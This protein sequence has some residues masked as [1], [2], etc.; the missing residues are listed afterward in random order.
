MA[1]GVPETSSARGLDF[2]FE[3]VITTSLEE[4]GERFM[5]L[6][7]KTQDEPSEKLVHDLRVAARR[8]MATL[9][10]VNTVTADAHLDAIWNRLRRWLKASG[11]LRDT[12][13]QVL[14]VRELL[15][16][17]P[18][19]EPFLTILL[20]RE[21]MVIKRIL[22]T[23]KKGTL[24]VVQKDVDAVCGRLRVLCQHPVTR[25]AVEA[26]VSGAAGRAFV[27]ATER[28]LLIDRKR[29]V[30]IHRFRLSFKKLRYTMEALQPFLQGIPGQQ[31]EAMNAYQQKMGDIQDV[32]VLRSMIHAYAVK[33]GMTRNPDLSAVQ[34]ELMSRRVVLVDRFMR[35]AM[36]FYRFW[37]GE[38]TVNS[39]QPSPLKIARASW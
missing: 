13:V 10:I 22:R 17:Y 2:V 38:F 19:L 30:T 26:G 35:A 7:K 9:D 3:A 23:V 20:L 21:N 8:L 16:A 36:D 12:Q 25:K 28:F 34:A 27:R 37:P 32:E 11:P 14:S 31:L 33:R 1:E 29:V 39:A 18:I 5:R 4:R 15:P 6:L 24:T